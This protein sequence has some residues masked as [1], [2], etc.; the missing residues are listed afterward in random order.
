[1]NT[2][3]KK[4]ID[5][6]MNNVTDG[7][8]PFGAVIV[9]DNKIVAEGVN[10]LHL[11]HDISGHAEMIAIRKAQKLFQTN[12]LSEFT[13]YASGEPCAMCLTAM[14]FAGIKDIYFCQSIDDAKK[15]GLTKSSEIYEDLKLNREE[16]SIV[17]KQVNLSN[18]E[19]PMQYWQS[20]Q[21]KE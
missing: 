11:I 5:L 9:R 12:D 20:K 15:V 10:E 6:A 1:M 13:I 19:N 18:A 7:G 14:Y 8:Q 4:A 2:Y 21:N 16:R 3:M 17:M